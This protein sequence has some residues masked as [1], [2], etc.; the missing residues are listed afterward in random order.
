MAGLER[1]QANREE[2]KEREGRE[3]DS[4]DGGKHKRERTEVPSPGKCRQDQG[5]GAAE[6]PPHA[7]QTT[8]AQE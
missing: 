5:T 2:K 1:K 7:G 6:L 8:D 3:E 4:E